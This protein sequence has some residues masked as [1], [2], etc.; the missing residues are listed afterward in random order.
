MRLSGVRKQVDDGFHGRHHVLNVSARTGA[1]NALGDLLHSGVRR[2]EHVVGVD[3]HT[4]ATG[5]KVIFRD[6]IVR[7]RHRH[8]WNAFVQFVVRHHERA[9][10]VERFP[11]RVN[12]DGVGA[13]GD[14]RLR[15]TNGLGLTRA[16]DKG[17]DARDHHELFVASRLGRRGNLGAKRRNVFQ[18]LHARRPKQTVLLQTALVL[19]VWFPFGH[20]CGERRRPERVELVAADAH[21]VRDDTAQTVVRFQHAQRSRRF[22]F[23]QRV[24][25]RRD[26]KFRRASFDTFDAID[27][28]GRRYSLRAFGSRKLTHAHR[29]FEHV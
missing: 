24:V 23:L 13:R 1:Q 28:H 26:A 4:D 3:A 10:L 15:A 7:R 9:D 14:V 6:V 16:A 27:E 17:L 2:A 22:E 18:V 29:Y 5:K 8:H 19:D 21:G 20:G 25:E 11:T 12:H